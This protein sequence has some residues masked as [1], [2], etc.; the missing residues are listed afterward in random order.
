VKEK[1]GGENLARRKKEK[2]RSKHYLK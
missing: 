2:E 1:T